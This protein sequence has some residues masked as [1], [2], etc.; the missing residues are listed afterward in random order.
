MLLYNGIIILDYDPSTD[1][2]ISSMPDIQAFSLSEVSFCLERIV[3]SVTSYDIKHL[4]LDSSKSV[5]QIG[6][7]EYQAVALQ[8]G[9]S[10]METGLKKVARVGTTDALREEKSARTTQ[11]LGAELQLPIAFRNFTSQQ[12]AIDWLRA[13]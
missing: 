4:L 9:M 5:V 7:E 6:N 13:T 8:F 2:L 12:E 3:E 10:L 11:E 1:I